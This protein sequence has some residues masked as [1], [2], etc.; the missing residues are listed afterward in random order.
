LEF[1]VE[2]PQAQTIG[3]PLDRPENFKTFEIPF[4]SENKWGTQ[5]TQLEFREVLLNFNLGIFFVSIIY[6]YIYIYMGS[7][8][9]IYVSSHCGWAQQ[10]GSH[11]LPQAHA[12]SVANVDVAC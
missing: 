7:Y 3:A 12:Q 11:P 4:N 6:I 5:G 9:I 10:F 8:N 1:E 2:I